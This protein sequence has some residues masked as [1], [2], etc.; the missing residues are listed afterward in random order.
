MKMKVY[1]TVTDLEV[2]MGFVNLITSLPVQIFLVFSSKGVL[3]HTTSHHF[4][5]LR[6]PCR[7]FQLTNSTNLS[8]FCRRVPYIHCDHLSSPYFAFKNT[9]GFIIYPFTAEGAGSFH[10]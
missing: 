8:S 9:V 7:G 1:S 4:G 10:L 5:D 6:L 2:S 3:L